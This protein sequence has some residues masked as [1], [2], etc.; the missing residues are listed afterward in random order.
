MQRIVTAAFEQGL[1]QHAA[2][3]ERVNALRR[4]APVVQVKEVVER[5]Q[6]YEVWQ[7]DQVEWPATST[8]VTNLSRPPV[9]WSEYQVRTLLDLCVTPFLTIP[10]AYI[11]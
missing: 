3:G 5:P 7:Q 1:F 4:G 9:H 2:V 11:C 6:I 10:L 8:P